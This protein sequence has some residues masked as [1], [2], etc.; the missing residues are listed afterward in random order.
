[1]DGGAVLH[2]NGTKELENLLGYLQL[3][4][5]NLTID[6]KKKGGLNEGP[7][8]VKNNLT[9]SGFTTVAKALPLHAK[10]PQLLGRDQLLRAEVDQWLHYANNNILPA[11]RA[12]DKSQI[13]TVLKE[14]NT[15][16]ADKT[17]L[18]GEA[19]SVADIVVFACVHNEMKKL[20]AMQRE[21]LVNFSRWYDALQ[22]TPRV[23]QKFPHVIVHRTSLYI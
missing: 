8:L 20:A 22:N 15:F 1:M 17:F 23:R 7:T 6:K 9:V 11:E 10:Q 5:P 21:D 3:R 19:V 13:R 14:L 18:V 4:P 16:L 2:L 12:D